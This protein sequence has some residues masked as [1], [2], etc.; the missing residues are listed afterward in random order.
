MAQE[1][2]YHRNCKTEYLR[3]QADFDTSPVDRNDSLAFAELIMHL[4]E[5]VDTSHK[6]AD[7]IR[8][9]KDVYSELSGV[10]TSLQV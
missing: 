10:A 2:H 7:L 6:L 9:Y 8:L 3:R 5:N 4:E 1:I